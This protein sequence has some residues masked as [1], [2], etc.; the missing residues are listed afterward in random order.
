[1]NIKTSNTLRNVLKETGGKF[2]K[3]F[4][5]NVLIRDKELWFSTDSY[6]NN[7]RITKKRLEIRESMGCFYGYNRII[8]FVWYENGKYHYFS[9][10]EYPIN[11]QASKV[12]QFFDAGLGMCEYVESEVL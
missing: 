6:E 8:Y 10:G 2:Y 12:I 7:F 1:M 11:F 3:S 9:Y 5:L 4:V